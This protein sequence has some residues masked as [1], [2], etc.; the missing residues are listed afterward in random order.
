MAIGVIGQRRQEAYQSHYLRRREHAARSEDIKHRWSGYMLLHEKSG[1]G[2]G[3]QRI[4]SPQ[5][6]VRRIT[7]K[8]CRC[9]QVGEA[10][11]VRQKFRAQQQNVYPPI[12][13]E[14]I[15]KKTAALRR[16]TKLLEELVVLSKDR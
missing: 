11:A 16:F 15:C 5:Q 2:D 3:F 8:T 10:L 6:R 7:R 14:V 12:A 4:D 13:P 9:L 1:V